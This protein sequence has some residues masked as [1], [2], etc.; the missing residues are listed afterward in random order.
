MYLCHISPQFRKQ[1]AYQGM[2]SRVDFVRCAQGRTE[3]ISILLPVESVLLKEHL[4]RCRNEIFMYLS[5][6]VCIEF[7]SFSFVD[8]VTF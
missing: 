4:T 1:E 8:P 5:G 3:Y 6:P 2:V 7:L